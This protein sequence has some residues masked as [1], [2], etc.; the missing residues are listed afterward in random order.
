MSK[1]QRAISTK[2]LAKFFDEK[3]A[4]T[5]ENAIYCASEKLCQKDE[6]LKDAYSKFSYQKIG[7]LV[8]FPKQTDQIMCDIDKC[9]KGWESCVFIEFRE[10][11]DKERNAQTQPPE[12]SEGEYQC[13]SK[14]CRSKKCY[15]FTM[16]TRSS[17]E[18]STIYVVCSKC[19]ERFTL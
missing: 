6:H 12:I 8:N 4:K 19:G 5:F 3:K 18:G 17:D 13:K 2:T 7:E 10:R 15:Y 11:E 16:Q 14:I 9:I 1:R